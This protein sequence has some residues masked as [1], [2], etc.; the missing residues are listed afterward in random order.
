MA[1]TRDSHPD[2]LTSAGGRLFFGADDGIHGYELWTTDGTRRGTRLVRDIV[3]GRTSSWPSYLTRVDQSVFFFSFTRRGHELWTSNGTTTGTRLVKV[4]TPAEVLDRYD[5]DDEELDLDPSPVGVIDG[6]FLFSA[7]HG[8]HYQELWTSD[9]TRA[10]TRVVREFAMGG[11]SSPY[12]GLAAGSERVYFSAEDGAHGNEP[13]VSDGTKGGTRLVKDVRPGSRG[14]I[15]RCCHLDE[16]DFPEPFAEVRGVVLFAADDGVHG[17]ELWKT[18][19]RK[20]APCLSRTSSLAA[21]LR[22]R[23]N[24]PDSVTPCISER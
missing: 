8:A 6:E 4:V 11:P 17:Q 10:G 16:V 23:P 20:W 18:D 13:W 15:P 12:T 2:W 1:R 21:N 9:G 24:S 7:I 19:G 5:E 22:S 14:S 3:Q